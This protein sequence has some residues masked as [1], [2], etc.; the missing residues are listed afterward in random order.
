MNS[1]ALHMTRKFMTDLFNIIRHYQIIL[2]NHCNL[3]HNTINVWY[4]LQ[5]KG[6]KNTHFIYLTWPES[7]QTNLSAKY[8]FIINIYI[9]YIYIFQ[10]NSVNIKT[11]APLKNCAPF[12]CS[13]ILVWVSLCVYSYHKIHNK[14]VSVQFCSRSHCSKHDVQKHT[15]IPMIKIKYSVKQRWSC[16]T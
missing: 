6:H 16:K 7:E 9:I 4:L 1:N 10:S 3:P 13:L 14:T 8:S 11:S 5:L 2:N 12:P 15:H